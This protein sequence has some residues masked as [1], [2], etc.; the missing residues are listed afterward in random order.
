V[1]VPI[2]GNGLRFVFFLSTGGRSSNGR[3]PDS[4]SGYLGSNPSLPANLFHCSTLI[5]PA[6]TSNFGAVF[7]LR[8]PLCRHGIADG[9]TTLGSC[10][11]GHLCRRNII[12]HCGRHR[13]FREVQRHDT[14]GRHQTVQFERHCIAVIKIK[15]FSAQKSCRRTK[16]SSQQQHSVQLGKSCRTIEMPCDGV[17]AYVRSSQKPCRT[18]SPRCTQ[19]RVQPEKRGSPGRNRENRGIIQA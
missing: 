16:N 17:Q 5:S 12:P 9:S 7:P 19:S 11:N 3:T 15:Y 18:E 2:I 8:H 14:G 4:G 6:S 13:H 1:A 10:E